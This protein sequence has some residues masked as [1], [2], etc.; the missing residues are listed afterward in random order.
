VEALV[1]DYV[2]VLF[3][4][5][6]WQILRSEGGLGPGGFVNRPTASWKQCARRPL[7]GW[8]GALCS[9]LTVSDLSC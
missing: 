9:Q 6:G 7:Y 2:A 1:M 8:S 5:D 4:F 3:R